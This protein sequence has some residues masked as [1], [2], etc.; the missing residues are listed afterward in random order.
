M[1]NRIHTDFLEIISTILIVFY[2]FYITN[3]VKIIVLYYRIVKKKG[4]FFKSQDCKCSRM[5]K[6]LLKNGREAYQNSLIGARFVNKIE[7]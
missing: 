5:L 1:R 2:Y 7:C 6:I 3:F 4:F